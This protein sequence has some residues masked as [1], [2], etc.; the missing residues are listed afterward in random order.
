METVKVAL[1]GFGTIGTGA[2]R[3]LLDHSSQVTRAVGKKVELVKICDQDITRP[4]TV[5]VP[6]GMLTDQLSEI[7]DDP[8]IEAVIQL[9]GGTETARSIMFELLRSGKDVVTANKALIAQHGPELFEEARKLRRTIAFEAAVA[10]GIPI[11][12]SLATSLQA[13]RIET[14]YAI[15]NGTSNFILSQMGEH[16]TEYAAAVAEAQQLGFAE[17]DPTMDVD[18]TDAVQKLTIL[19][20]LAFGANVNWRDIPKTGVDIVSVADLESASELGYSIKLLA[21]AES[22]EEGLELHVSPTL[23]RKTSPLAE[24]RDAYNAIT[25]IGDAV[26]EVFFH[27]LGAGEMPTASA[28]IGDLI[29][30]LC[31]RSAITFN[32]LSL[33]SELRESTPVRNPADLVGRN[34]LRL[35]VEDRSRVLSE[36]AGV[37]GEYGISIS[38]VIQRGEQPEMMAE[39][40]LIIM[41][42]PAREGDLLEA[43]EKMNHLDCVRGETVRLRVRD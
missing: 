17:A 5:D 29:D 19:A 43:I 7:T 15:L 4:R 41:T 36:I 10:G 35:L 33:W 6:E 32:T 21:V 18:G 42:H 24:V 22:T 26:G 13:N 1:V 28:V 20:Q 37:L 40:P 9:I 8:E 30:T 27:G 11:I 34:Y 25:V 12:S 16:G 3:I 39:V 31:G 23:V 14:I 38:S 2:A